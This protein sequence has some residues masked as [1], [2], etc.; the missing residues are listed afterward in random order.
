MWELILFGLSM[1]VGTVT[2]SIYNIILTNQVSY[3]TV[4]VIPQVGGEYYLSVLG[5]VTPIINLFY[6][7]I[8]G[9]VRG[10]SP[11]FSYNYSAH[12]NGRVREAY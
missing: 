2:F 9:L 12:N 1:L 4:E 7:T 11:I 10:S 3:V 5:A 8:F 6:F